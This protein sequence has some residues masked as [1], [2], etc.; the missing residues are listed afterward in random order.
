MGTRFLR[1]DQTYDSKAQIPYDHL[2]PGP[3]RFLTTPQDTVLVLVTS[4]APNQNQAFN[5][6][7][8]RILVIAAN[9]RYVH[10]IE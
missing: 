1:Q 4:S 3:N 5:G 8:I 7:R 2:A 9:G 6:Q 10:G